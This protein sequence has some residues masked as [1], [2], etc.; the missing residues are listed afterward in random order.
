MLAGVVCIRVK[1]KIKVNINV[2]SIVD[3]DYGSGRESMDLFNW[4]LNCFKESG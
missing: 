3:M 1:V 4:N 2:M